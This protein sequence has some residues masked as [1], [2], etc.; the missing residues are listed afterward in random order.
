ML[1]IA[2][3]GVSISGA[4]VGGEAIKESKVPDCSDP[5]V[6]AI[7]GKCDAGKMVRVGAV[8][9]FFDSVFDL[10]AVPTNQLA[11]IRDVTFY[12]DM[13]S[14]AAVGGPVEATFKVAGAY[15]RSDT[16]AWLRTTDGNTI[17]LDAAAQTGTLTMAN[18]GA[19]YPL[20]S[21]PPTSSAGRR[22]ETAAD[23]PMVATK[24]GRQLAESHATRRRE[25]GF[26]GALM[27]SGS[28]TMMAST[29]LDRRREL[30]FSGALM[31]SGSFTM[32]ASTS[33]G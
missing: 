24:T 23:A 33:Y 18:G 17:E 22:L 21:T 3:V 6:A 4:M 10:P 31:T 14:D 2:L 26:S 16:Q 28:F 8:E 9:S 15:K 20:S 30:G 1:I 7:S 32:M 12:A 29:T 5:A 11:Y 19:V 13:T 27:T 25:L